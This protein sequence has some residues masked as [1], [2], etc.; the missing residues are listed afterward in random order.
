MGRLEKTTDPL[1]LHLDFVCQQVSCGYAQGDGLVFEKIFDKARE[2][3]IL[4]QYCPV[5][6]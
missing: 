1:A 2:I 4:S 5:K 3:D 6:N